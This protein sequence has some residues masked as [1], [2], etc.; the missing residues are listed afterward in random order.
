[1]G[2]Y[3]TNV[4]RGSHRVL[5]AFFFDSSSHPAPI[6]YSSLISLSHSP[7]FAPSLS[8]GRYSLSIEY[9]L[10]DTLQT[11]MLRDASSVMAKL[12]DDI[13]VIQDKDIA[14]AQGNYLMRLGDLLTIRNAIHMR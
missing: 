8:L 9:I 10:V 5:G 4:P 1:M 3:S 6:V 12:D 2:L 11:L 14:T 13:A 7:T